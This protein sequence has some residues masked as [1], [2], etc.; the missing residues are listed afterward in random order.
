MRYRRAVEKLRLLA[1][2]C[3]ST[4][5]LPV[6]EP[7][8]REAYVFGEVLDGA[9]PVEVVEVALTL[10]LRPDEVPWGSRPSGTEWLVHSLRLDKGG[11][12]TGGVRG[13]CRCTPCR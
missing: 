8:P 11:F 10:N 5:R 12:R 7:F 4:T 1:D 2:A 13:P 9:D 3:Q 6:E